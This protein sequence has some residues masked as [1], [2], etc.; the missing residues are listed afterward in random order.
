MR[1]RL[2][3]RHAHA[4]AAMRM[5]PR[6]LLSDACTRGPCSP[7]ACS[8]QPPCTRGSIPC[9]RLKLQQLCSIAR[10]RQAPPRVEAGHARVGRHGRADLAALPQARLD[11]HRRQRAPQVQGRVDPDVHGRGRRKRRHAAGPIRGHMLRLRRPASPR[12]A[13]A[14]RGWHAAGGGA[15]CT[16]RCLSYLDQEYNLYNRVMASHSR[17]GSIHCMQLHSE[18]SIAERSTARAHLA[19]AQWQTCPPPASYKALNQR[20]T[21]P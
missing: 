20:R 6:P 11:P 10:H 7:W 17:N 16:G 9:T 5:R 19:T 18:H 12:A 13:W 14:R 21:H 15:I 1:M 3:M 8:E 2:R 4:H